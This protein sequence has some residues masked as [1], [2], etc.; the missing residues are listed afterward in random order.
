MLARVAGLPC[1]LI[2]LSSVLC[3]AVSCERVQ[4]V[5]MPSTPGMFAVTNGTA[6]LADVLDAASLEAALEC[7]GA[8]QQASG[9]GVAAEAATAASATLDLEPME[10][11]VQPRGFHPGTPVA[12]GILGAV[13]LVQTQSRSALML[14]L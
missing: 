13:M 6:D 3:R 10:D 11:A 8:R 7:C 9:A 2:T 5:E 12:V 4:V 1:I 14:G